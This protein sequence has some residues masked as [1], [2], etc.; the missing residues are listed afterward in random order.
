MSTLGSLRALLENQINVG[1]TTAG[2]DPTS[3]LL[4]T[5]INSA[6]RLIARRDRPR[7]L[8][9]ATPSSQTITINSNTITYPTTIAGITSAYYKYSSGTW[10]ELTFKQLK[11]MIYLEGESNFF[12]TANTGDPSM[13]AL[14]GLSIIFNKY[15]SRTETASVNLYGA[16]YPTELTADASVSAFPSDYD[17][18]IV[19]ESARLWSQ[20]DD[21]SD[22][23]IKF[24][25]LAQI[26]RDELR[27]SLNSVDN[28]VVTLDP[29]TYGGL[30]GV[31]MAN[32]NTFFS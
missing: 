19:Y 5:Y 8:W 31:N 4:N 3:T 15:F 28:I 22:L 7:E 13:Y 2:T 30:Q 9:L 27:Q 25:Q 14:Q 1:V 10:K 12:D 32:P 18:L 24:Q 20:R 17:M 21:D 29:Y 23:Q 16:T 6:Y 26:E 11:E